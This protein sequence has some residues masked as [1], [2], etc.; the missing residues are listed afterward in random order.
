MAKKN[1]G[2][3]GFTLPMPQTILGCRHEGRNN[4][5]ALAWVS[6]VNYNPALMMISVGKRHFSNA[7][8]ME[9]GEFSVNIPSVDMVEVTDFVG[10]V[11]GSKLDKS[12]LF[13]VEQGELENAPVIC[14]CPVS[15]QCKVFNSMELPNDT[16]F[17][18]EVVAT[19][20]DE[21]VLVDGVPD[22]KKVNPF[23][24]TMPDNRYW[25]VGQCVG[26]AWHDGKKLK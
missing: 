13:E 6:R 3:Q 24:L 18:G 21:E 20:C 26:R 10:L 9:T 19:W 7:A 15:I 2:I 17:V 4:F 16:L 14:Q 11:S 25:D 23:T 5:M 12:G 22:I 8:I 1:I